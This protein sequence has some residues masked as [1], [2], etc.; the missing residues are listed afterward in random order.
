MVDI[1]APGADVT[2]CDMLGKEGYFD[3]GPDATPDE[4][5]E[6][7]GDYVAGVN[8]TSF[9]C[10][11]TA[12]V[13]ALVWSTYPKLTNVQVRELLQQSATKIDLD[14]GQ[15]QDGYS[16]R[17]GYGQVNA[18]AALQRAAE[19]ADDGSGKHKP[20]L[21]NNSEVTVPNDGQPASASDIL[22]ALLRLRHERD[23]SGRSKAIQELP[24]PK[25]VALRRSQL[26]EAI[27]P[28]PQSYFVR[29]HE[30]VLKPSATWFVMLLDDA[31]PIQAQRFWQ[32]VRSDAA[33]EQLDK[34]K[35]A[36]QEAGRIAVVVPRDVLR[37]RQRLD[38]FA[39]AGTLPAIYPVYEQGGSLLVPL[40]TLS[41][42]MKKGAGD[43]AKQSVFAEAKSLGLRSAKEDGD[44]TRFAQTETSEHAN[45][46]VAVASLAKLDGVQW[47]EPDFATRPLALPPKP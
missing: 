5:G 37:E 12:G 27:E 13:A 46:F 19:V 45:L 17:Y 32:V 14:G 34:I 42:R 20:P 35:I 40:G 26:A 7:P 6:H 29:G 8:G 38:E 3:G 1:S 25:T 10:P 18:L 41:L 16:D 31:G 21:T 33:E 39:G 36:A 15:W 9:A 23:D 4:N 44:I 11:M 2:S 24:N 43:V 30:I 22:A 47:C 28:Q